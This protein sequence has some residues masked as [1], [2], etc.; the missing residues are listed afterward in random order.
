[1]PNLII[2]DSLNFSH[3]FGFIF[4]FKWSPISEKTPDIF[5]ENDADDVFF[6][7]QVLNSNIRINLI[8]G[9]RR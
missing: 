2:I 3:I 7:K 6:A 4:L 1:M 8:A 9:F 5:I